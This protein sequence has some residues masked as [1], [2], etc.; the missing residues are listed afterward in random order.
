METS[1]VLFHP[2]LPY[3]FETGSLMSLELDQQAQRP[4]CLCLPTALGLPAAQYVAFYTG[5]WT[6]TQALVAVQQVGAKS[7]RHSWW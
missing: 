3:Y 4:S 5:A 6:Q 7:L 2:S 1:G